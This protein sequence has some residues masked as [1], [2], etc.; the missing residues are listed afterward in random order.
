MKICPV[1]QLRY[2]D[3]T[4][5][6]MVDGELLQPLTDPNI[7]A[8]LGGRYAV[9]ARLG[10]GGMATVY[11][12]TH[13][14]IE[15]Q[16]AVK[17]LHERFAGDR[18]LRERLHREA[19]STA[20]LAHPNI[21]EMY[22]FGTTDDDVPF[23]VMELLEGQTL[24][25]F[26]KDQAR[27]RP[28]RAIQLGLQIARGLARAHDF[29]VVHRDIKPENI[30]VC[31][32]EDGEPVVKLV[33]FGIALSPEDPRL[34][35]TGQLIGSPKYMAPERFRGRDVSFPSDLYS[36]GIV[37]FE[38]VTGNLPFASSSAPGFMIHH[39][40]TIPPRVRS[41]IAEC[42]S[43]LDELIASLLEKDPAQRPVDAHQVV[44]AL[45][46]MAT[47]KARRVRRVTAY[48]REVP[49]GEASRLDQWVERIAKYGS[50]LDRQ[51][52]AGK[53]ATEPLRETLAE[54]QATLGRLTRLRKQG[55]EAHERMESLAQELQTDRELLGRAVH[56]IAADLSRARTQQKR[57]APTG[58]PA[59]P[60]NESGTKCRERFL[61]TLAQA[62]HAHAVSPT[63]PS[64]DTLA[65]FRN[66]VATYADWLSAHRQEQ[67]SSNPPP[68]SENASDVADLEFQLEALRTQL[69][70]RERAVQR[71][72]ASMED[73]LAQNGEERRQLELRL[74]ALSQQFERAL[75]KTGT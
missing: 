41:I 54:L 67:L 3:D 35:H 66:V 55:L 75:K 23:L 21:V 48:S 60:A 6:C 11:R 13:S 45:N 42:P 22:D 40:E 1:C 24:Y 73:E 4:A 29:R 68:A 30:F 25:Q 65:A 18:P 44:S 14:L 47:S 5:R 36:L 56:V 2:R 70:E 72:R 39:L 51:T 52:L 38:I 46:D 71:K 33:D 49:V 27:I 63:A 8:V 57:H 37:L 58:Q 7:G 74:L 26:L 20:A 16:V 17:I 43:A 34:T 69:Q 64:D 62:Q 28:P 12:A 32:S 19:Q 9:E 61:N 50:T 31:D 10:S 53:P 59:S 15:R